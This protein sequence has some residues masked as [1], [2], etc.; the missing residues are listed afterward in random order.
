[1]K[2]ENRIIY[3]VS[4]EPWGVHYLSKHHYALHLQEKNEVVF[5]TQGEKWQV[6]KGPNDIT[7][8]S[9]KPVKGNRFLPHPLRARSNKKTWLKIANTCGKNPD[10]IWSFDN[11]ILPHLDQSNASFSL[12]HI[13]DLNMDYSFATHAESADLAVGT[14]PYIVQKLKQYQSNSRFLHHGCIPRTQNRKNERPTA[15]YL[16]KHLIKYLDRP[17]VIS[18]I[19]KH[20]SVQ[21]RFIG[22]IEPNNIQGDLSPEDDAFVLNMQSLEN[23]TLVGSIPQNQLNKELEKADIYFLAYQQE[24]HEQVANPHKVMELLSTGKPVL[25]FPLEAFK[26]NRFLKIFHN[27]EDYLQQFNDIVEQSRNSMEPNQ[28]QV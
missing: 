5:I 13:V 7:L 22:G 14:T 9:F 4:P 6:S 3:L 27:S 25:S 17:F 28:P 10:I 23:V 15:V 20:P 2:L 1:M 16:G 12:A 24:A 19:K 26:G 21:F 11:S 8:L 18:L